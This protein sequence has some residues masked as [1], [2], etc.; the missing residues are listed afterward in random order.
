MVYLYVEL[1][2][3]GPLHLYIQDLLHLELGKCGSPAKLGPYLGIPGASEFYPLVA[4]YVY[5]GLIPPQ[6]TQTAG[7]G[8]GNG[9]L[10]DYSGIALALDGGFKA[11]IIEGIHEAVHPPAVELLQGVSSHG[12]YYHAVIS[13]EVIHHLIFVI[14]CNTIPPFHLRHSK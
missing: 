11:G 1:R 8:Y 7:H 12:I 10:A 3:Y 9:Y 14:E 6:E 4:P 13:L 5:L 2:P